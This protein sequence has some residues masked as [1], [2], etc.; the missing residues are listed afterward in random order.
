MSKKNIMYLDPSLAETYQAPIDPKTGEVWAEKQWEL[1]ELGTDARYENDDELRK[2][3]L[4]KYWA[5]RDGVTF[6]DRPYICQHTLMLGAAFKD[7]ETPELMLS[8]HPNTWAKFPEEAKAGFTVEEV[9][10]YRFT[11]DGAS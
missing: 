7:V 8:C 10:E 2:E 9:R 4:A 1:I 6:E 3:A 5:A 11:G